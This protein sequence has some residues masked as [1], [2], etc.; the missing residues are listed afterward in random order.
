MAARVVCVLVVG[1]MSAVA[2]AAGPPV[3]IPL[4]FGQVAPVV[5]EGPEIVIT[6]NPIDAGVVASGTIVEFRVTLANE[7]DHSVRLNNLGVCK[8]LSIPEEYLGFVL[9][10]QTTKDLT[11][12]FRAPFFTN[13]IEDEFFV[14][15]GPDDEHETHYVVPFHVQAAGD[16]DWDGTYGTG[17]YRLTCFIPEEANEGILQAAPRKAGAV[18]IGF[19]YAA[20]QVPWLAVGINDNAVRFVLDR[21]KIDPGT[22]EN[23]FAR[24]ELYLYTNAIP[25]WQPCRVLVRIPGQGS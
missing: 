15:V 17:P 7:S 20:T 11:L 10:P 5:L 24:A 23:D 25:T 2:L 6:P 1:A 21:S 22:A 12:Q 3:F 18:I 14:S 4:G 19:A 16:F 13:V 8:L 9:A